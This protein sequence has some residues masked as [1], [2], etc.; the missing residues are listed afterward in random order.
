[1]KA[2]HRG[3]VPLGGVLIPVF[4]LENG[5]RVLLEKGLSNSLEIKQGSKQAGGKR[6]LAFLRD[7]GF[8][9]HVPPS[10][11]DD[12]E[13]PIAFKFE[14]ITYTSVVSSTFTDVLNCL[15]RIGRMSPE[16]A[17]RLGASFRLAET[18]RDSIVTT[19]LDVMIDTFTGYRRLHE[20]DALREILSKYLTDNE[21]KWA[22][23]FPDEFWVK[24]M[25]I[26]GLPSYKAIKRPSYVGHWVNDIVYDRLAPGV[27]QK[28]CELNPR[29]EHGERGHCHHQHLTED[30]G[31]PELKEHLTKVMY[32]MDIA[33]N[34]TH[35]KRIL[36]QTL[37]KCGDTYQLKLGDI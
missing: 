14:G 24:L 3:E 28:L 31:L 27:R 9:K 7:S 5:F 12:L 20:P 6:V 15:S 32:A 36:D 22:K 21:R 34:D 4:V 11:I 18:F 10:L 16:H 13:N 23:T 25:I 8:E 30:H 2:T 35:F 37:P 19:G 1:M 17:K 33:T 29:L 26:K